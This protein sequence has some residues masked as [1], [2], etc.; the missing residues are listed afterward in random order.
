MTRTRTFLSFLI[1]A[2]LAT[3]AIAATATITSAG[4]GDDDDEVA[5]AQREA[6]EAQREAERAHE[7][8]M[9]AQERA[10]R[11]AERSQQRAGRAAGKHAAK[12]AKGQIAE[13][14]KEARKQI[15]QARKA[16]EHAPMPD[17]IRKRV[18]ERLER[19]AKLVDSHLDRATRGD[20]DEFE[21]EMEAMGE[22]LEAE[23]EAMG[24]ELAQ[25]GE[26]WSSWGALAGSH[27]GWS[28]SMGDDDDVVIAPVAPVAPVPPVPPVA[29]RAPA[30]PV[31]PTPFDIDA[32]DIDIV[33]D[34]DFGDLALSPDQLDQ[35]DVIFAAE[36][37]VIDPARE[38]IEVLSEQLRT[39]L[40]GSDLDEARLGG[41][42]DAISAQEASIR[43]AQIMAWAK[44]KKLLDG[45]QRDRVENARVKTRKGRR[46]R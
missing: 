35:L 36:G 23:M 24:E 1:P 16:I 31:P 33:I 32:S 11:A 46:V 7:E 8:A 34:L 37:R 12:A 43:R 6:A 28:F 14:R 40:A 45:D 26:D 9:R 22:A 10:E 21:A 44:S 30:P 5:E 13:A 15:E 4:A 39:E 27:G 19:A 18:L 38:R 3:A 42:V 17:K 25:M 41:L 2:A 29:P 20:M